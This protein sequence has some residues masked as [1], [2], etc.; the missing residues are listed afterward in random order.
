MIAIKNVLAA[1]DFSDASAVALNYAR[2]LSRSYQATL[3]VVHIVDD[4]RW[5]YSL[6]MTPALMVGVQ[7]S[8]E[9]AANEQMTSL[10]TAEDL[11]QLHARRHVATAMSA[12]DAIVHYAE[13]EHI[14]IVV[15][16]THGRS[17][18]SRV[19]MGSVAERVVRMAPCPML[20]VRSHER[21]F[22]APDALMR[23]EHAAPPVSTPIEGSHS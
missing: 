14:D 15:I 1:T 23:A 9:D 12:A 3:H 16:G 19:L 4:L 22:L 6:D 13:R 11:T 20:T 7:E 8:L 21:S 5:R 18:L 17:G 10:V 2:E